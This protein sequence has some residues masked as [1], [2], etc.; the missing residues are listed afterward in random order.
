MNEAHSY[1]DG[2]FNQ[3]HSNDQPPLPSLGD[4]LSPLGLARPA[5][6][7]W[8]GGQCSTFLKRRQEVC[9]S[10][11]AHHPMHEAFSRCLE[12]LRF[13]L[14]TTGLSAANLTIERIV[15]YRAACQE[16]SDLINTHV[17]KPY[18]SPGAAVVG[19]LPI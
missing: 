7:D 14:S 6:Q 5:A 12:L 2:M 3:Q 18:T 1:A 11:A 16:Y 10:I 9:S 15:A 17:C 13:M 19:A 4:I 8:T